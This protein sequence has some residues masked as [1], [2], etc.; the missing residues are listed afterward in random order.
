[1]TVKGFIVQAPEC[2]LLVSGVMLCVTFFIVTPFIS[3]LSVVV[4]SG[5]APV[6]NVIKTL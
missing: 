4:P 3:R 6:S 1:M 5:M 2:H